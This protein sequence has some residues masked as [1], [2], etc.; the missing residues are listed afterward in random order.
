MN[1]GVQ[2][3]HRRD[4]YLILTLLLPYS[5]LI[6]TS[7]KPHPYLKGSNKLIMKDIG[8]IIYT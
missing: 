4:T 7:W 8:L 2:T 6:E 5:Y 3:R 1:E